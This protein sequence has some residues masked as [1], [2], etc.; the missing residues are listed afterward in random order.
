MKLSHANV[1]IDLDGIACYHAIH[2]ID[3]PADPT[4]IYDVALP[5]FLDCVEAHGIRATLFVIASDLAHE[6]VAEALRGAHERGHEVAS[7]SFAHPYGLRRWSDEAIRED[8]EAA[9]RA[10]EDA[11]GARPSGFR[12]PGYNIDD[13]LLGFILERGY[14]YDSS[15]FAC[16][17]YYFAKAAVMGAM[18]LAGTPS[19]SSMTHPAALLAPLQPY[20]PSRASFARPAPRAG[21]GLPIWEIPMG[22]VRGV[23][24]PVIGTSIGALSP[25]AAALLGRAL[26]K[27]QPTIQLEF[28]GIDFLDRH[29]DAISDALAD[30]QPDARRALASKLDAYHALFDAVGLA[31]S[32]VT[33][34]GLCDVLDARE[35]AQA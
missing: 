19:R 2:A 29:D 8:L 10:I 24:F 7:H 9:D 14:R 3:G 26:L 13:R 18:A 28:H 34:D 16:P 33:L 5:R 12:T 32:W 23:R 30:R 25:R 31:R 35:G 17:P 4:A 27:G 20:R 21:E 11:T 6:G 1:S 22:V 15:V